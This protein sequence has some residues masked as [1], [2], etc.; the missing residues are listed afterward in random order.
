MQRLD[1]RPDVTVSVD[2][3]QIQ[4]VFIN[5]ISNAIEALEVAKCLRI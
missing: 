4:Q 3:T 5:L 1:Q 2:L